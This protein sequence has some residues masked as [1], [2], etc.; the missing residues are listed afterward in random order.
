MERMT[1]PPKD[2]TEP[3]MELEIFRYR[4]DQED[5][6]TFQTYEVPFREEWVILD[7]INYIKDE[8]DGTI[9]HRWSCQMGVCGSCGMLVNGV[10]VLTCA[11]FLKDYYPEP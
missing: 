10:P 8:I 7:A 1:A 2:I 5:Q 3:T 9:S 11:V 4:P 6:P